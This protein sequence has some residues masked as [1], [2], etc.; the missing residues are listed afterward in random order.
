MTAKKTAKTVMYLNKMSVAEI[1]FFVDVN[2]ELCKEKWSYVRYGRNLRAAYSALMK[3]RQ[4]IITINGLLNLP[5]TITS[6]GVDL[7]GVIAKFKSDYIKVETFNDDP[8]EDHLFAALSRIDRS[9]WK[10][11]VTKPVKNKDSKEYEYK[12]FIEALLRKLN[13][14][15][16]IQYTFLA[17]SKTSKKKGK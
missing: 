8:I 7:A 14:V 10:D 17:G 16:G 6:G 11:A 2:D 4:S 9:A 5:W 1:L 12:K 13:E 3:D 15:S